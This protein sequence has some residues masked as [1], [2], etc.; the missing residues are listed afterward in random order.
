ML[1]FLTGTG[2]AVSAG[3]NAY[4]PLLAIGLSARLLDF[5]TLP[6][7]WAWL[8]NPWVL[9]V[10]GLLFAIEIVADKIPVVDGFNDWLQTIVRPTAGGLAFGS[11]ST[12]TTLAV[13][14]PAAFFSNNQ[15]VPIAFGAAIALIVHVTKATIRPVVNVATVGLATPVISAVEDTG[16][17]AVSILAILVP[18]LILLVI[19]LVVWMIWW[20]MRRRKRRNGRPPREST[21]SPLT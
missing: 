11:G 2:L 12:A 10:L 15:W 18:I 9:A 8:E 1:E 6:E 3:L 5:V 17:I 21:V 14:D 4:V 20:T 13:T 7:G 19:P 16:S